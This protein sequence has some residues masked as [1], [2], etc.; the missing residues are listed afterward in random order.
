M[1]FLSTGAVLF[2]AIAIQANAAVMLTQVN[3]GS[4]QGAE[5]IRTIDFNP[6][7]GTGT[8][9]RNGGAFVGYFNTG[10]NLNSTLVFEMLGVADPTSITVGNLTAV[11]GNT[12]TPTG[13]DVEVHV[14]RVS[15]TGTIQASDHHNSALQLM[16]NY[17]GDGTAGLNVSLDAAGQAALGT[18]LQT[19]WVEGEF[20]FIGLQSDTIIPSGNRTEGLTYNS[21]GLEVTAVPEPSSFALLALSSLGLLRRRRA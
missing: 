10:H 1:K 20:L 6:A 11:Q 21:V 8:A 17:D 18:W 7:N 13:I 12:G 15:P 5:A 2:T 3:D 9:L 4:N 19:N 14:I 16:A